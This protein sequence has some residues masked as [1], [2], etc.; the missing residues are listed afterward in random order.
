MVSDH[1]HTSGELLVEAWQTLLPPLQL[2]L[3]T[4]RFSLRNGHFQSFLGLGALKQDV[5]ACLL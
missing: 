1:P 4:G 3:Q 5:Q 2:T